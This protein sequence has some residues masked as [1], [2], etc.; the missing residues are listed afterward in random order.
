MSKKIN[1]L[2]NVSYTGSVYSW[3]IYLENTNSSSIVENWAF[4]NEKKSFF[5]ELNEFPIEDNT[6]D[7]YAGCEGKVGGKLTCIVTINN[8]K[9][10]ENVLCQNID[11]NYT[12]KSYI[13]D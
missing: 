3:E 2:L 8:A 5:K 11:S 12:H 13:I 4:D 9:Q 10:P 6:L 7:V 1:I